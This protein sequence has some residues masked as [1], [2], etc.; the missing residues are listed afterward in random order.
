M[1]LEVHGNYFLRHVVVVQL[2]VAQ[3]HV[4]IQSKVFSAKQ[5]EVERTYL[6]KQLIENIN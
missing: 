2:V 3:S 4:D 5:T 1:V 6:Y